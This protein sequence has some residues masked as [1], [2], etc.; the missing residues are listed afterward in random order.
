MENI[1]FDLKRLKYLGK[2]AIIGKTVRIR[3]PEETIIGDYTIIDDFTYISC[4]LT[5]GS[6]CHIAPNVNI[7]G[8]SGRVTLGNFVGISCGGSVHPMSEDYVSASFQMPTIPKEFQ[9]GAVCGDIVIEDYALLGARSVVL[10][11]VHLPEGFASAAHTI[12]AKKKYEPWVLYGG[13]KARK[14]VRREHARAL[15]CGRKLLNTER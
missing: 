9:F 12:I 6:Y 3:K 5:T 15:E 14:L 13:P 11:G 10:P 4:S 8:G 2:G 1:Y 7:S